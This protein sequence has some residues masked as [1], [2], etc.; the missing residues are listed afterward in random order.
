MASPTT[1]N[2]KNLEALGAERLAT[3]LMEIAAGNAAAKTRLRLELAGRT[4]PE[5][6][7]RAV[8][9]RLTA[10]AASRSIIEAHKIKTVATELEAQRRAIADHVAPADSRE[11]ID[12]L[13]RLLGCANPVI[14]RCYGND[15][16]FRLLFAD[17]LDDLAAVARAANA[18][19]AGLAERAFAAIRD[20]KYAIH[21][22]SVETLAPALGATGLE[23]LRALVTAWR[24]EAT[25]T[26]PQ[27]ERRVVMWGSGGP[28]Y[29]DQVEAR[30]RVW[31]TEYFLKCIADAI[32][33]VDAYIAQYD[34]A[35]RKVPGVAA[36]IARRLLGAGRI[37]E[38][39]AAIENTDLTKRRAPGAEWE[40]VRI[41]TLEALGRGVEAQTARHERFK[42]TLDPDHL[43][44]YLRKLP[45][46]EDF[47]AER[48]AIAYALAHPDIP[49]ALAFLIDWP[50]LGEAA[51]LVLDRAAMLD[52]NFYELLT[53]AADALQESY[54]L[55][56]TVLRRAMIG[57]TLS[58][59]RAKR[60]RHAARHLAECA[61]AAARIPS[62]SPF[63][64]HERY[65]AA[66]RS[67]YRRNVAF[68]DEV[69]RAGRK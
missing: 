46:F 21:E 54:P 3:L 52:G 44:A 68:W 25:A 23:R 19:P 63:P 26:P 22:E 5:E 47:E 65:S 6:V 36:S 69:E 9:K 34:A 10:I 18:D 7:R 48:N 4:G 53:P 61:A 1:L 42:A 8:A 24:D 33:D 64:D 50:A 38:A 30:S 51:R 55:A 43:R 17:A 29:E 32:G 60:Y 37:V 59:A 27:E 41:D 12:L 56:A 57:F 13:W 31:R 39:W 11:A 20:D 40:E 66:L 28:V 15:E 14:E 45:E 35:A 16:P 67:A 62:C 58:K 2:A 49:R